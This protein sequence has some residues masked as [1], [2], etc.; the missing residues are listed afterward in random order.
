MYY[1][2]TLSASARPEAERGATR[3]EAPGLFPQFAS[4]GRFVVDGL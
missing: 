3:G 4:Q 2:R 1:T